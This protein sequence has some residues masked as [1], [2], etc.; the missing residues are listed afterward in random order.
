MPQTPLTLASKLR[1]P[2][3]VVMQDI[4][5]E[6]VLL[7]LRTERYYGL[8]EVGTAILTALRDDGSAQTAYNA[9]LATYEVDGQALERD[10]LDLLSDLLGHGLL[11]ILE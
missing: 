3:D 7:D 1:I 5:G 9:V 4:A 10:L 8:N 11:E 6:S 2:T